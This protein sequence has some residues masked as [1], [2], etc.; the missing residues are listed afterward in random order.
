MIHAAAKKEK[1]I[2]QFKHDFDKEMVY[3]NKMV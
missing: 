3:N 2:F 1:K